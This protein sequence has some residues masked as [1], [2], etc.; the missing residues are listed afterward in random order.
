MLFHVLAEI[1]GILNSEATILDLTLPAKSVSLQNS[2]IGKL[3]SGIMGVAI[4]TSHVEVD[5]CLG[6][7]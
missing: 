1:I 2:S 3:D 6:V 7:L 4:G 5:I